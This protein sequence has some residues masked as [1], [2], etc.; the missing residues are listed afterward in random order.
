HCLRR[1]L[2]GLICLFSPLLHVPSCARSI[3]NGPLLCGLAPN[4]ARFRPIFM[5]ALKMLSTVR[6]P[7]SLRAA[8]EASAMDAMH[9]QDAQSGVPPNWHGVI[10]VCRSADKVCV[11]SAKT[12]SCGP[13]GGEANCRITDS[14]MSSFGYCFRN[15]S[16]SLMARVR[17]S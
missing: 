9:P 5:E 13:T 6:I 1:D 14:G 8:I 17:S 10:F 4:L 11:V 12:Q 15:C 7:P 16:I 3:S 2:H